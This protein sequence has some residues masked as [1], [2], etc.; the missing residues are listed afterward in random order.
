MN[1]RAFVRNLGIFNSEEQARIENVTIAVGGV[2][3]DGGEIAELLTRMG[4]GNGSGELRLAD[5]DVFEIE[6]T[7]RQNACTSET[8]GENKALAVG[9]QLREI[10]PDINLKIYTDGVTK[11]NVDEFVEG[12]D[13]VI[14]E[15]EFTLHQIAVMIA[16]SA[17]VK[18]I[19]VLT[20]MNV[21]FA[22]VVTTYH[23]KGKTIESQL[24]LSTDMPIDEVADHKVSAKRWAPYIPSYVD[25]KVLRE[26][27]EGKR[28]MPSI[29]PGMSVAASATA[30]QALWNIFEQKNHRPKP[31]YFK[32]ALVIDVGAQFAK[33]ISFDL[34]SYYRH[35]MNV[36]IKNLLGNPHADY[37]QYEV[38]Q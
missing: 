6:N 4:V 10:N 28:V 30:T 9:A 3:G 1:E 36:W 12:A 13:L 14:D 11:E 18:N 25:L 31:V 17:R 27:T 7:N 35:G 21:G 2:G 29:S 32:R 24:G 8:I 19:P 37:W 15:S 26:V 38:S 22:G 33:T 16:R 5:P 20:G 34:K 23:P